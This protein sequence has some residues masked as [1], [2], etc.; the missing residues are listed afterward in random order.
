MRPVGLV[1]LWACG[2]VSPSAG[3]S[4]DDQPVSPSALRS[5]ASVSGHGP[6]AAT[7]GWYSWMDYCLSNN[8]SVMPVT[9]LGSETIGRAPAGAIHGTPVGTGPAVT[10]FPTQLPM[11]PIIAA[12]AKLGAINRCARFE[13]TWA[14]VGKAGQP[15]TRLAGNR[16][17]AQSRANYCSINQCVV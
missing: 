12:A 17:R 8:P 6:A 1:G 4:S 10:V 13:G 3:R 14:G 15:L 9:R 16:V 7:G 11:W 2:L 5:L